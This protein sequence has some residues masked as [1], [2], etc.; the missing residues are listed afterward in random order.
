MK[1]VR[2]IKIVKARK[3]VKVVPQV[4]PLNTVA[5]RVGL[6]AGI[7]AGTVSR[8]EV[9]AAVLHDVE[10]RNRRKPVVV[11]DIRFSSIT[12][13]ALYLMRQEKVKQGMAFTRRLDTLKHTIA[14]WCNADTVPGYY[15]S[16]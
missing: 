14:N 8:A 5:G 12:N 2:N 6:I 9:E 7:T 11:E 16:E 1:T 3:P 10:P 4:F 15:W 13:A